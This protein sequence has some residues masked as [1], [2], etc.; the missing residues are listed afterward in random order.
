M[1]EMVYTILLADGTSL[2]GVHKNGDNYI[3]PGE[4]DTSIFTTSNLS[5]VII[6]YGDTEEYH[7]HMDY[8]EPYFEDPDNTWF[9]LYDIPDDVIKQQQF[10]NAIAILAQAT[11]DDTAAEAAA[12]LFP[13]WSGDGVQ[14]SK[15]DRV[16]YNER[17]A[18]CLQPHTSQPD[19]APGVA[20]SLWVWVSDPGVEWPAW[21]QPVGAHDAYNTGA[22]VSHNGKHWISTSDGNVWEP[23]VYGWTEQD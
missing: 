3:Y 10:N 13:E 18:K 22:K 8:I 15:D 14:Y 21:V 23:G 17:L 7:T 11:L 20:P 1:D 2:E 19:W 4:L 12:V 5:P 9:V 16:R 6:T